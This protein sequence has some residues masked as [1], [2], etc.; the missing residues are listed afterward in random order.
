MVLELHTWGPAFGL[1]SIEPE[2]IATIA[3]CQRVIPKGLWSVVADY[4]TTVGT[5]GSLPILFDDGVATATGFEDIVAYLRNHPEVAEDLDADLSSGQLTDRTAFIAFLQSTATPLVDLSLFVSA[6][7]YNT[8][9]SSAYTAI[10]PWFANY[11]VPPRRRN[12]A[13]ARTAHMGLSSLDV[14]T[15]AGEAFAPGRGTA[16]SEY[17]AAKRA[18]GM[19]TD[20]QPNTVHMGRGKGIRGF[21]GT[22]VPAARFRLDSLTNELLE[23]LADVLG[24]YDYLSKGN[25]ISSL[26]CLAFGYL[27][28]LLYP[29]VP[30]AWVKESIQTKFPRIAS[31]IRRLRVECFLHEDVKPADVWSL[32]SSRPNV[33]TGQMLLPWQ[34]RWQGLAANVYRGVWELAG[35]LPLVSKLVQS[36]SIVHLESASAS[37]RVKS[38]LPSPVVVNTVLGLTAA[39]TVGLVSLA[40]HHR[41]S[42]RDGALIFWALQPSVGLGEAGDILSIFAH[43]GMY[44]QF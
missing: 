43:P 31:Y 3:Y 27:S 4:N 36:T 44:S 15:R 25:G 7:N 12:L 30:Q 11:T 32:S 33:T 18:A 16:S 2:C 37:S 26:D 9:T 41:R 29:A 35:N 13:R 28:L 1:P 19:P 38:S 42:P 17:E 24:K 21:L 6:E 23:P 22:P 8:T 39:A 5:T 14:D 34:G 40:I 20:G 10:L